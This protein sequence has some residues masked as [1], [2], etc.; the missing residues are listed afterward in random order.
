MIDDNEMTEMSKR[1]EMM[2]D[3]ETR[4]NK[5][6]DTR[7]Y[8]QMNLNHNTTEGSAVAVMGSP[9]MSYAPTNTSN[10]K[11]ML[12]PKNPPDTKITNTSTSL[13]SYESKST[14]SPDTGT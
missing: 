3:S 12:I 4:T 10:S 2:I 1:T 8:E 7:G 14:V 9:E 6:H 13:A 5:G 11:V